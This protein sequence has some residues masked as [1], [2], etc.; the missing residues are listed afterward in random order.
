MSFIRILGPLLGLGVAASAA[1]AEPVDIAGMARTCAGCHGPDG[2]SPGAT[3]PSIAGLRAAHFTD[4]MHRYRNGSRDFYV[5]R[6]IAK[7]LDDGEIDRLSAHFAAKAFTPSPAAID[8]ALAAKGAMLAKGCNGCHGADGQGDDKAPRLAG[9]P[10]AYLTSAMAAYASGQRRD[11]G[12]MTAEIKRLSD[13][14]RLQLSHYYAS[15]R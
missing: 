1:A 2:A 5:M 12:E 7:G 11:A 15:R 6:Y 4:A 9:Q 14:Q 10:A 13:A 8:A 3:I